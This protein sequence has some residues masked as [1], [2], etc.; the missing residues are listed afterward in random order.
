MIIIFIE[1]SLHTLK[2]RGAFL[3]SNVFTEIM[4]LQNVTTEII[5]IIK[6]PV[7]NEYNGLTEQQVD[8]FIMAGS[9]IVLVMIG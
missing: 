3:L 5:E 2:V 7:T 6:Q 9:W 4:K 8:L 1:P